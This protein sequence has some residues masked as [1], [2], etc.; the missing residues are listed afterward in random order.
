MAGPDEVQQALEVDGRGGRDG[1]RHGAIL[2]A[3]QGRRSAS[4]DNVGMAFSGTAGQP[5]SATDAGEPGQGLGLPP[6]TRPGTHTHALT[7][8]S[9]IVRKR[10]TSWDDGQAD[11]EWRGLTVLA[12]LAPDLAPR[13]IRRETENGAPVLV[14]SRLPGEPLGGEP[15][16]ATQTR[17]LAKALRR[18]FSAPVEPDIPDRAYNPSVMR[19]LVRTWAEED[20]DLSGCLQPELTREA[21]DHAREWVHRAAGQQHDAVVDPV[22]A[23]G[24]GNLANLV[25]DGRL[26]RL[27]DFEEFGRSDLTYEL[28]DIAEHVSSRL[29]GLLD[30]PALVA[31]LGL[32]AAQ[33][34]RFKAHR[35]LLATFWFFML[36]PGGRGFARNPPGSTENQARHLLD[37]LGSEDRRHR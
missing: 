24:D 13:P 23:L 25:W 15:V 35:Q 4:S 11:R 9:G 12:R 32:T 36:L 21:L 17:A 8:A 33:Q 37:L 31:P 20:H 14:M 26:C 29:D 3:G 28:A 22:L 7:F 27:V 2:P 5:G 16:T 10:Y 6:T 34:T 1:P 18:L 19:T 30:V